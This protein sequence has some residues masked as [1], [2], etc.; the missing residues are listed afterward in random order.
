[1]QRVPLPVVQAPR[2]H[3]GRNVR[4]QEEGS[5]VAHT[6]SRSGPIVI[7]TMMVVGVTLTAAGVTT[8]VVVE[9]GGGSADPGC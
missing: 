7:T 4:D 3:A 1:M 2:G 6:P 5:V 9:A 8:D